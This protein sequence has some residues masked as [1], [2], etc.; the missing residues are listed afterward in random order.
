MG[1]Y[2]RQYSRGPEPGFHVARPASA[3][4]QLVLIT[5]AV[6][7]AQ[8]LAWPMVNEIFA[9]RSDWVVRPWR[10]YELLSYGFLHST[11]D[12]GHIL[13]N[14]LILYM[15]GQEVEY[16]YGRREFV[17]FYLAG[18]VFSG[19]VWSL[20]ELLSIGPAALRAAP[21][22]QIPG[23][24]GA[25]GAIS[26]VVALFALNFPHRQVLFMFFIPMPMWLV[27]VIGIL[28]DV[29][30]AISRDPNDN[31]AFM[32]HLGG[33]LFG[34]MYYKFNWSFS[35]FIPDS[36]RP[37]MPRA[38]PKLRVHEPDEDEP[39]DLSVQ[40]DAILKKI[41]DKGQDSLSWNERRI[42]EKASRRYQ[43]KRK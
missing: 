18:I 22:D 39:D 41:Q 43:Q 9:L 40:V 19:L 8:W 1:L 32:A 24:V 14:M 29:R 13:I 16:R 23:V 38:R 2:D 4:M 42:L 33:A 35:R 36:F 25:S 3:T 7:V 12:V 6:Y 37:R 31:V 20:S 5:A 11:A 26:A 15:F 17:A 27:A 10:A 28:Y 30:G 34:L 21:A